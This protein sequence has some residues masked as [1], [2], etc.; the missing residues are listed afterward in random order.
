[1][2]G[3]IFKGLLEAGVRKY[4]IPDGCF[5]VISGFKFEFDPR[6]PVLDRVIESSIRDEF[7]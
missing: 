1:M 5:P 3:R 6:K 4:P 7:D 2:P